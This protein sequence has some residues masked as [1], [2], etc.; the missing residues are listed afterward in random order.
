MATEHQMEEQRKPEILEADLSSML[1]E[2]A[3]F[4]ETNVAAL[5]WLTPPP[6]GNLLS[7]KDLLVMLGAIV[8]HNSQPKNVS[9]SK[10][11][12]ASFSLTLWA[13]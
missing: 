11:E 2:V 1:L 8:L 7:A 10:E 13:K 12:E 9:N 4:G 5:P 3:A 6:I